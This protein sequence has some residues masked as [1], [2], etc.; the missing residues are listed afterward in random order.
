MVRQV[1]RTHTILA[2]NSEKVLQFRSTRCETRSQRESRARRRLTVSADLPA[3]RNRSPTAGLRS[4]AADVH[5]VLLVAGDE[6]PAITVE[7]QPHRVLSFRPFFSQRSP[8]LPNSQMDS[9]SLVNTWMRSFSLPRPA[10]DRRH[11]AART[12]ARGAH[13]RGCQLAESAQELASGRENLA[14]KVRQ[15]ARHSTVRTWMRLLFCS[16]VK[17]SRRW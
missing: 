10:R 12:K 6:Q 15:T 13:R 8:S 2:E 3:R 7:G 9:P 16:A 1:L 17:T 4:I 5:A 11:R 14:Y